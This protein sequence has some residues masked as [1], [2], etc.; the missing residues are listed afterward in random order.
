MPGCRGVWQW[1]IG[2]YS[3]NCRFA[4]TKRRLCQFLKKHYNQLNNKSFF[5]WPECVEAEAERKGD[6]FLA[7]LCRFS[8]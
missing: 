6:G 7:E 8:G 1:V 3:L 4:G 5:V 2:M